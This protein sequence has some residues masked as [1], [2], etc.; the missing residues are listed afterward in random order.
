[1]SAIQPDPSWLNDT[2]TMEK[3]LGEGD[4]NKPSYDTPITLAPV[5][6]DLTKD[7]SGVG[8]NRTIVANATVFLFAIYTQGYPEAIDDSWLQ[9]RLTFKGHP[10]KVVDWSEHEEPD[11]GKPF[12]IELKVI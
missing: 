6:V 12:S 4:Y 8:A 2:V 1:M 3:Y 11:T 10:Y 5:R 9:G 7:F